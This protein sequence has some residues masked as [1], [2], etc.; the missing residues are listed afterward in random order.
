MN[1]FPEGGIPE[2]NGIPVELE[3]KAVKQYVMGETLTPYNFDLLQ[4][5]FEGRIIK[6]LESLVSAHALYLADMETDI[7]DR[8]IT[9]YQRIAVEDAITFI[10]G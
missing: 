2:A 6:Q 10:K 1:D 3:V 7:M 9:H 5:Y 4:N 8:A